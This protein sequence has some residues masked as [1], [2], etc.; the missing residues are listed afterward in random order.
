MKGVAHNSFSL[1][2][3]GCSALQHSFFPN[4][5]DSSHPL[6]LPTPAP[7]SFSLSFPPSLPLAF[8]FLHYFMPL[9]SVAYLCCFCRCFCHA[10]SLPSFPSAPATS[11]LQ[12]Q[13][14]VAV[15]VFPVFTFFFLLFSSLMLLL[16]LLL[17]L[18]G[19]VKI[20]SIVWS[21]L[22][23]VAGGGGGR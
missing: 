18:R 10:S 21:F 6:A 4:L 22:W 2:R 13:R 20:K 16:L 14:R 8:P 17:L 7:S 1:M 3:C 9:V 5:S 11:K 15:S 19:P 12:L 23:Q